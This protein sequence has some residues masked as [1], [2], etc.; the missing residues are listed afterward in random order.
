MTAEVRRYRFFG[1]FFW[2][3]E[4]HL[5]RALTSRAKYAMEQHAQ[6]HAFR[7]ESEVLGAGTARAFCDVTVLPEGYSTNTGWV[8]TSSGP[9]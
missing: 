4:C 3:A 9:R 6:W 5:C 8:T 1:A 7:G 2:K